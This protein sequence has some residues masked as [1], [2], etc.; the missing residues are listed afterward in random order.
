M[1]NWIVYKG[2]KIEATPNE[3][4]DGS[5]WTTQVQLVDDTGASATNRTY[6]AGNR[7][8]TKEEAIGRCIEYGKQIV[9]GE[10]NPP[11]SDGR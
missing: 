3:A 7:W 6:E 1:E 9:D 5:G 2:V 4:A 11:P 8:P 10:L